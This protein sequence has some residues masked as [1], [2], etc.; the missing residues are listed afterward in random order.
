MRFP[1]ETGYDPPFPAVEIMLS[2]SE[3]GRRTD[4]LQALLDTGS[5]G[6]IVPLD[7]LW[8]IRA[9]VLSDARISSHWGEMRPVQ[10]F[11]VDIHLAD[12]VFPSV[13]VVGDD[14]GTEIILGRNVLNKLT[15]VFDGPR[16][17]TEI[18]A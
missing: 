2:S 18:K 12:L 14:Q 3:Q 7:R 16:Q 9:T 6:T 8:E 10:L 15:A 13:I 17:T 1:F 4:K 11:S 5:D